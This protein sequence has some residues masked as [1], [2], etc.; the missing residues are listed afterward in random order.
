[1]WRLN[2]FDIQFGR[3][4]IEF[5]VYNK[6]TKNSRYGVRV[7]NAKSFPAMVQ[8]CAEQLAW[9]NQYYTQMP[10]EMLDKKARKLKRT[11]LAC[12]VSCVEQSCGVESTNC[13]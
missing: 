3:K 5:N 11:Y 8:S 1:M 4:N 2:S 10:D 7:D 13:V 9:N 6:S 12:G